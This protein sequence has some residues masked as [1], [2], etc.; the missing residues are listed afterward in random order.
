MR[1]AR[2][3][4]APADC[5]H[6]GLPIPADATFSFEAGGA[7][8]SFCCG[9]CEAVS[10]SID[11]LDLGDYYRLRAMAAERPGD[12]RADFTAYDAPEVQARFVRPAPEGG[13]EAELVIEGMRCAACAW[14]VEQAVGRAPGI[15]AV[16]VDFAGRRARI[17]W[18]REA[19]PLSSI[20]AAIQ[21]V[22]YR[23]WP[24]DEGRLE[25]VERGEKRDLLR[26]LAIAALGMMQVMMYAWPAYVAAEGEVTAD[27]MGLMHWAALVLTLPVLAYSAAPFF[28]GAWRDLRARHAGMDVPIALGLG[29]AYAASAWNTATGAGPVY[30]DSVTMFVFLLLGSRYLEMLARARAADSLRHLA[31]LVP[32]QALRLAPGSENVGERVALANLAAGDRVLVRPGDSVPADGLLESAA[33]EVNEAWMSGESRTLSRARGEKVLAGSINAGSGFVVRVEHAG[34]DTQLAAI[35]RLIDRAGSERPPAMDA[36]Q[37]AA[38]I[39]VKGVLVAAALAALAWMFIDP[40]RW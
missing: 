2:T 15:L 24:Y 31:R 23:A 34:G 20:L 22:G 40:A 1:P 35:H 12:A 37:R 16:Q 6:C 3:A 39:F 29:A 4:L 7:W 17:R 32:Q 36:A 14:L 27:V 10:R 33:A 28:R 8:R 13:E 18:Q 38:R 25:Q 5:Y 11:D 9:G 30:F 26:R 21:R 19:A